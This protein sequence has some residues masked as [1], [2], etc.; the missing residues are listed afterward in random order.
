[1]E[2]LFKIVICS[3]I[4]LCG[5]IFLGGMILSFFTKKLQELYPQECEYNSKESALK[6]CILWPYF[7]KQ[8]IKHRKTRKKK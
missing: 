7:L 4:L 5:Y 6:Q 1:M 8:C 2:T 3:F